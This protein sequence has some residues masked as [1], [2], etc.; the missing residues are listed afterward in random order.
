VY[1]M[2][3]HLMRKLGSWDEGYEIASGEDLDLAFTAWVNDLE[4]LYDQRVLV[5]HV[6]KGSASRLG[7]WQSLWARNRRR[8]FEKWMGDGAVPKLGTCDPER[9][10]RNRATA[11]AVAGWMERYF[12]LRDRPQTV[13]RRWRRVAHQWGATGR[14]NVGTR[15][16]RWGRAGWRRARPH[17]S[18]QVA[19]RVRSLGKRV[20]RMLVER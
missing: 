15:V 16:S 12:T 17:I 10:A 7:D 11:R 1:V 13:G 14:K 20:E 5:D 19:S 3:T 4:I 9:Y 6:G 18:S 8:F 2:N